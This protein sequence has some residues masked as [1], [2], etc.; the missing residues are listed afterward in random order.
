MRLRITIPIA[1]AI[2][3]LARPSASLKHPSNNNNNNRQQYQLSSRRQLLT[4]SSA[5][6]FGALFLPSFVEPAAAGSLL[7]DFG[8]NPSKIDDKPSTP[9]APPVSSKRKEQSA[10]EPNLRSNYY[11][12]TNKQRYLPRIKK[13][14]DMIGDVS[15]A[16]GNE[17]WSAVENF[18]KNVA[19]DTILPMK[20]YTSSLTGQG[21]N[22]KVLYAQT[23]NADAKEFESNQKVLVKAIAKRN[24]ELASK[25]LEG[26]ATALQDY[27]VVGGLTGPDGGGDIPT[28]DDIRRAAIRNQKG[29]F[30]DSIKT[31]DVRVSGTG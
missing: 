8:S 13:C 28:V 31:R 15:V 20:L 16:I 6:A 7:E 9:S 23:M 11:Y 19:D 2:T 14:N 29:R 27:R 25:A 4:Q 5:F 26:M 24:P 10:I 22:V 17:D 3:L 1:V 30:E 18:A 21:T 12:P